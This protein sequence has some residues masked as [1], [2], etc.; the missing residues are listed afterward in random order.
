[1]WRG[2]KCAA[3]VG[4]AGRFLRRGAPEE[5]TQAP[6]T[7]HLQPQ[8]LGLFPRKVPLQPMLGSGPGLEVRERPLQG[9]DGS[10]EVFVLGKQA[11]G[12][13]NGQQQ[14]RHFP[15][16]PAAFSRAAHALSGGTASRKP[17]QSS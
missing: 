13:Q 10:P 17:S 8:Q 12:T 2:A 11:L 6:Q 3:G 4:A 16:S 7:P 14:V 1:M 9:L 5:A 15:P